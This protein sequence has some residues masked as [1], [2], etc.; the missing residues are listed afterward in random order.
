[1]SNMPVSGGAGESCGRLTPTK[2]SGT[3][4]RPKPRAAAAAWDARARGRRRGGQIPA[5]RARTCTCRRRPSRLA[6]GRRARGRRGGAVLRVPGLS[7]AR[8]HSPDEPTVAAAGAQRRSQSSTER[9]SKQRE[10]EDYRRPLPLHSAAAGALRWEPPREC[11]SAPAPGAEPRA[12]SGRARGGK[13]GLE[14][15]QGRG[16]RGAW[17]TRTLPRP[18][19]PGGALRRYRGGGP[20]CLCGRFPW[21]PE[22]AGSKPC[23]PGLHRQSRVHFECAGL[24]RSRKMSLR[25]E[26][27]TARTDLR[28]GAHVYL[29]RVCLSVS[30]GWGD[31]RRERVIEPRSRSSSSYW[32]VRECRFCACL[33]IFCVNCYKISTPPPPSGPPIRKSEDTDPSS[34]NLIKKR[35]SPYASV[36]FMGY[37]SGP[38]PSF[39]ILFSSFRGNK[40]E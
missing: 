12:L 2:G 34:Q 40:E 27:K 29:Q 32:S 8:P 14:A 4:R 38:G 37:T 18:L 7:R 19:A 9:A 39:C 20:R 26:L 30:G 21:E 3:S 11:G 15:E 28:L 10:A 13:A 23:F 35:Q 25:C 24:T 16:W 22:R 17:G 1:M 6:R 33:L 5:R 31:G 36:C